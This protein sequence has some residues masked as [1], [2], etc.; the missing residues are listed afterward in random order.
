M[1]FLYLKGRRKEVNNP[2]GFSATGISLGR[3][4]YCRGGQICISSRLTISDES[5]VLTEIGYLS[6]LLRV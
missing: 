6:H 2:H 3:L 1:L 4:C 5:S